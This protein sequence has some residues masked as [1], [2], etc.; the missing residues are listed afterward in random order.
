MGT[1]DVKKVLYIL[2]LIIGITSPLFAI[3]I[4]KENQQ[5]SADIKIFITDNKY[6]QRLNAIVYIA[7]SKYEAGDKYYIWHYTKNRYEPC[8][9]RAYFTSN[10]YDADWVI[11][12]TKHKSEAK[13]IR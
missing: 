2:M 3:E 1:L 5:Y 8:V 6:D 9:T 13:W 7:D 12:I 4:Y 11:Y 10:K